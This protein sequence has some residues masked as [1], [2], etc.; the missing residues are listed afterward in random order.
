MNK[1]LPHYAPGAG[2]PVFEDGDMFTVIVPL[3]QEVTPEVTL[4]VTLEVTPE[5]M[6]M[7]KVIQGEMGRRE[8]QASLGLTDEK[9]F[10]QHYQQPAVLL[11]LLEMTIPDK[12]NSRLQ[13]YRLTQKGR[14]ML[15]E[16][17]DPTGTLT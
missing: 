6:A 12:P 16:R 3:V 15:E 9:H 10:R 4:E 2:K 7:L 14:R 1:Y 13:K 5:V 11:G 8:I 17:E